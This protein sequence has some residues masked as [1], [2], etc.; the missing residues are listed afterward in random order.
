MSGDTEAA[1]GGTR[2]EMSLEVEDVVDGGV[3]RD[4]TLS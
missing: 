4:K 2:D 1:E 3:D